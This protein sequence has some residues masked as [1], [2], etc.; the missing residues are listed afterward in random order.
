MC[1]P[2]YYDVTYEI[3]PW[4]NRQRTPSKKRA[5]KQWKELHHT[6][7]RLGGWVEYV[8]PEKDQPDMVFTANA[9]LVHGKRCVISKFKFKERSGEEAPFRQWFIDHGFEIVELDGFNFEGEGDALFAGEKL[10]YGHGFRTDK[11][12]GDILKNKLGLKSVI[13]CEL[14]NSYF[15]HL[16]T[17]FA[18]IN[19]NQALYFPGAF[20]DDCQARLKNEI[21]LFP[22]PEADAKLFSCNAVF[23]GKSVILPAGCEQT[24]LIL[25]KLGFEPYLI[26]LDE[27]IKAGGAAK[28]LTLRV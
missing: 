16:D 1:C 24:S 4:M 19:A 25:K 3:N 14:T 22:V 18:P 10:F 11:E 26:E 2:D 8:N 7:L 23:L 15:Y 13:P 27:F 9:G 6:I 28:C 5:W 21:E 17:C 12:V 20:S